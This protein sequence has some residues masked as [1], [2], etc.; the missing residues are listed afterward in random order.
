MN[1]SEIKKI[2]EENLNREPSNGKIRNIVF[3]YDGESEFVEDI[4]GLEL[5]N[6]KILHLTDNNKLYIKYL[7][8][9][10]DVESNY[11]I[12]SP[13]PRPVPRENWLLD[14]EKYSE[15]FSTDKATVIMRDLGVKDETLRNVFKKYI[16][17]FG[18]KERYG[19][20]VSYNIETYTEE[21]ID[22][23]VLST[24]CKLQMPDF[25]LVTKTLLIEEI[26]EEDN[27]DGGGFKTG[28][29]DCNSGSW[30]KVV[31]ESNNARR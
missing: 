15:E 25:E 12:Y 8:E 3:W 20:F 21:K 9:K 5:E 6:A 13:K 14:I 31:L 11:L 30:P 26:E 23:A 22:I 24:L 28:D 17:F 16:K 7:L 19:R 29:A 2:L 4:K 1:L 27:N 18:N 10:E